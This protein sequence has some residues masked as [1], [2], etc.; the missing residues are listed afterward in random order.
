[1][2]ETECE[3]TAWGRIKFVFLIFFL[4]I[5]LVPRH[6]MA[7]RPHADIFHPIEHV[8]GDERADCPIGANGAWQN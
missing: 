1:M 3:A 2:H 6:Q 8:E 5:P 7:S 4:A